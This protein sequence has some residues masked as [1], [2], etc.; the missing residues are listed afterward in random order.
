M[1]RLSPT[2]LAVL[3]L[4]AA[5]PWVL[6]GCSLVGGG[7]PPAT[8]G[9]ECELIGEW[10]LVSIDGEAA[11][12]ALEVD[13]FTDGFLQLPNTD[14]NCSPVR[15]AFSG[16]ASL[17]D[18]EGTPRRFSIR[19]W[20]A[21][22]ECDDREQRVVIDL[23]TRATIEGDELTLVATTQDRALP[24]VRGLARG[25]QVRLVFERA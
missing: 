2:R 1:T 21:A 13:S 18:D 12:G 25:V 14:P 23:E 24:Q 19:L 8:F 11:S 20:Q 17:D 22:W 6:G 9:L 16:S 5:V 15:G 4:L 3:A 7:C 10:D